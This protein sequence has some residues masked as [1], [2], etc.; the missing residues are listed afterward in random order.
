M[1]CRNKIVSNCFIVSK[2]PFQ[3][4]NTSFHDNHAC[5]GIALKWH[6]NVVDHI[7]MWSIPFF[8][9]IIKLWGGQ[10]GGIWIPWQFHLTYILTTE[11]RQWESLINDVTLVSVHVFKCHCLFLQILLQAQKNSEWLIATLIKLNWIK[12]V[13]QE[14]KVVKASSPRYSWGLCIWSAREVLGSRARK[15]LLFTSL[16]G[17]R[18][19]WHVRVCALIH[20]GELSSPRSGLQAVKCMSSRSC[21]ASPWSQF[22]LI[23]WASNEARQAVI[24]YIHSVTQSSL[25]QY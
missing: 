15:S 9:N 11:P 8:R 6:W 1:S 10:F 13:V 4:N 23:R 16:E 17:W 7:G 21:I 3:L 12:H 14:Y 24:L 19:D 5:V 22:N 18:D 25:P 20:V 2:I